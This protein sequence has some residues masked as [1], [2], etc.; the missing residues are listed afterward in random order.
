[1]DIARHY[2]RAEVRCAPSQ[3][4]LPQTRSPWLSP[5]IEFCTATALSR[6]STGA[7]S[8]GKSCS[9]ENGSKKH[10]IMQLYERLRRRPERSR[11][12]PGSPVIKVIRGAGS[13]DSAIIWNDRTKLGTVIVVSVLAGMMFFWLALLL[14][15][16]GGFLIVWGQDPKRTEEFLAGLP[17]GEHLLKALGQRL[18]P[19]SRRGS[20]EPGRSGKCS[21]SREHVGESAER[22]S[23]EG[24]L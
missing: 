9:I 5:A 3:A 6:A 8:A 21:A 23:D 19:R 14:L 17:G 2:R 7:S 13:G 11:G 1:M 15:A 22:F 10:R 18:I 16:V 20:G 24:V 12:P 4:P